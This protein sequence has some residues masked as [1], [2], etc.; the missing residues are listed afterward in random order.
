MVCVKCQK[1]F[2]GGE[3]IEGKYRNLSNRKYCRECSPFGGHNTQKL[4][5]TLE[6]NKTKRKSGCYYNVKKYR[7]NL[8]RKCVDY[9]GGKC[10]LCGYSKSMR[11]LV[12]HHR[13]PEKKDFT[14]SRM[15]CKS[16]SSIKIELDK[17]QLLCS[18]CHGEAH[19]FLEKN[20]GA[21]S[22]SNELII[23]RPEDKVIPID[24]SIPIK[25]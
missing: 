21:S 23:D 3:R 15:S 2:K 5:L 9:L 12:F 24:L 4:H 17:C 22:K 16:F 13:N 20:K 25:E 1:Y 19:D 7:H 10:E 14:I 8:K 18:N 11:S 6:Y